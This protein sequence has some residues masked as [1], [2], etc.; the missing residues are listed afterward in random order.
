MITKKIQNAKRRIAKIKKDL[1]SLGEMKPGTLSKQFNVCGK[2]GCK[3]KA[4]KHPQKH[5]PYY[6]LSYSYGGKSKTEFVKKEE[7]E[8]VHEQIKNYKKFSDL[9]EKWVAISIEIAGLRRDLL[10]E[11][12]N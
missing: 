4:K 12:L 8:L 1:Q 2:A 11:D 9:T 5:G 10:R 6:Q 3:C 7:L